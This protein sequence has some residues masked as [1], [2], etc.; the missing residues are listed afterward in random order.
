MRKALILGGLILLAAAPSMAANPVIDAAKQPLG[1]LPDLTFP[2]APQPFGYAKASR[3]FKPN[4]P[5]PFP[6]LV[7]LPVCSGHANWYHSFD[8][9]R[10]ALD[11][12]YAVLVVDP[13]TPRRVAAEN[14]TP[15]AKVS[16]ARFRKDGFDAAEHLRKQ[17]FVDRDRIGLLGFS[18]GAMAGLVAA[19]EGQSAPDG[20]PAFRAIVSF[21]PVCF[22]RNFRSPITGGLIDLRYVPSKVVVPLQVQMGELDTEAPPKD[23][24][25]LLEEQKNKGA[26]VYFTVHKNATH[27]WETAALGSGS[28]RKKG[29]DGKEIVYR[30]NAQ[31]TA[32]SSKLAFDF[33]DRHVKGSR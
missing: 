9:A 17:P 22:A 21:Y 26:P 15:P 24:V 2:A 4:G 18:M 3:M 29:P 33:L 27:N 16:P 31:V 6:G 32:E 1:S 30:Y 28:F 7:V 12:G 25:P 11:R 10:A 13:L 5:G 19:G 20:R 23:C 14:C 8:W